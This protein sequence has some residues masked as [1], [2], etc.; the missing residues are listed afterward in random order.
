MYE[1][2]AFMTGIY[3]RC[4][5]HAERSPRWHGNAILAI[6]LSGFAIA[7]F[8]APIW[9]FVSY[10]VVVIGGVQIYMPAHSK[11][12]TKRDEIRKDQFAKT[13]KTRKLLKGTR[14]DK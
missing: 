7:L 14:F 2:S 8:L 9:V 5:D 10:F 12:W 3:N 13:M 4:L 1:L 6:A 11:V